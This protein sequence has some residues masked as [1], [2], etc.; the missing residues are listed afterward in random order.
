MSES[1]GGGS[2]LRE[3][4]MPRKLIPLSPG[5]QTIERKTTESSL[6]AEISRIYT[7]KIRHGVRGGRGK[8]WCR[9]ILN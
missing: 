8:L 4:F 9:Q 5:K 1:L 7:E 2:G 3:K 6:L